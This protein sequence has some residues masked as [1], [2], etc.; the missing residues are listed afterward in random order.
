MRAL[1]I[2]IVAA[3]ATGLMI[4]SLRHAELRKAN[5]Q[6]RRDV[7]EWQRQVADREQTTA[8]VAGAGITEAERSELLRLR[9]QAAQLRAAT[10]ELRQLRAQAS[11]P[12]APAQ[13]PGVVDR[14]EG[15]PT[16][17]ALPRESWRFAGYATPEA[18]FQSLMFSMSQGDYNASLASMS[19]DEA[20]REA[21]DKTPEQL[22]EKWQRAAA[23]FNTYR[24]IDRNEISAEEMVLVIYASGE[25]KAV[26]PM[27]LIKV[28]EEW[29]FAGAVTD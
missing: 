7:A 15:T 3:L 20:E 14:G 29:K 17:E 18:A 11:Q 16:G 1:V 8:P 25:K 19:P 28:G 6:L 13:T 22:R 23:Q 9:S 24:I 12:R 5:Q 2:C 10:N 26:L 27:K 21:K 4:Q